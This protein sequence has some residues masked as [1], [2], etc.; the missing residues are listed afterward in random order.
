MGWK[1]NLREASFRGIVFQVNSHGLDGGRRVVKHDFPMRDKGSTEDMGR[2]AKAF[3]VDAF[4][5]GDDYMRERDALI[6]ACDEAGSAELVHP[7]LGTLKVNCEGYSLHES[8]EE[9]RLARFT[10]TF[11][12][13]GEAEFPNSSVDAAAVAEEAA[14][15]VEAVALDDFAESFSLDGMPEYAIADV[16]AQ[17]IEAVG[18]VKDIANTV[19][20]IASGGVGIMKT[21]SDF[22]GGLNSMLNAPRLLGDSFSNLLKG[23]TG[24]FDSPFEA[25]KRL[26]D[27]FDFG[28]GSSSVSTTPISPKTA[29]R[30]RQAQNRDAIT[31]LIQRAAVIQTI[32]IAPTATFETVEDAREMSAIITDKIDSIMENPATVDAVYMAFQKARTAVVAAVP[33]ENVSLPNLVDY[34][35][36]KTLPSLVIAYDLYEDASREAEIVSRNR[37]SHPGFVPGAVPLKVIAD[38]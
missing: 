8:A 24:I 9:G 12:E 26:A 34:V 30:L 23:V 35:P 20:T 19:N 16:T 27:M 28:T 31:A 36:V 5:L 10:L 33:P 17:F 13:S 2:K 4:V 37:V 22:S 1:E 38:A 7:Y 11:C 3:T 21:L 14:D 6:S 25:A 32:R 18:K 29:T 15:E